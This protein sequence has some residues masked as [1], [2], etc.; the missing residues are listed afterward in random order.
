MAAIH[1]AA[2]FLPI[3]LSGIVQQGG[4]SVTTKHTVAFHF[5]LPYLTRE[6]S[7]TSL[8]VTTGPNV[9]VNTI[10]GLPFI[11][12]TRMIIDMSNQVAEL[13]ALDTAPFLMNYRQAMCTV[14]A[15]EPKANPIASHADVIKVSRES[16]NSMPRTSTPHPAP[17]ALCNRPS[18]PAR[19]RATHRPVLRRWEKR[20][21]LAQQPSPAILWKQTPMDYT[22]YQLSLRKC[23]CHLVLLCTAY[24][25][26]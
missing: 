19:L 14:P 20:C 10:L 25:C 9:T 22:T 7:S 4:E 3:I 12:Q 23:L 1:T 15:V 26:D 16:S 8:L 6:G 2:D 13:R 17:L 18:G 5:H 21:L 11:Q 24:A